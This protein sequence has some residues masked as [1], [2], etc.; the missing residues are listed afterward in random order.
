MGKYLREMKLL[1]INI[2]VFVIIVIL[3]FH[4]QIDQNN[5]L[6][7]GIGF[8]SMELG[9]LMGKNKKEDK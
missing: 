7:V 1:L 6:E 8:Y 9:F 2:L 3:M 4:S 5:L